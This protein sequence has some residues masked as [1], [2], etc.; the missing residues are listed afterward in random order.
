MTVTPCVA[1]LRLATVIACTAS[2]CGLAT[3]YRTEEAPM[4]GEKPTPRRL[5]REFQRGLSMI[6]LARKYGM[7]SL[8][9]QAAIRK[10]MRLW[11]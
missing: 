7:T 4:A 10:E 2:I 5:L 8:Q 1:A 3:H 9:V 6:G 11:R